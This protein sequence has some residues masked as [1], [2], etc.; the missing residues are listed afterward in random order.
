MG[1]PAAE[2]EV[3][4][5]NTVAEQGGDE[6]QRREKLWVDGNGENVE[7][8]LVVFMAGP[9]GVVACGR[10]SQNILCTKFLDRRG[11]QIFDW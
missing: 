9:S 11:F 6:S 4:E 5:T 7:E 3:E 10:K 2:V 1:L 8:G